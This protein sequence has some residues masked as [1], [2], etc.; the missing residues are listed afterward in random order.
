M[1]TLEPP[2]GLMGVGLCI[3]VPVIQIYCYRSGRQADCFAM[4][5]GLSPPLKTVKDYIL[6]CFESILQQQTNTLDTSC[7]CRIELMGIYNVSSILH[8]NRGYKV[9][10]FARNCVQLQHL[11]TIIFAAIHYQ[12]INWFF[13]AGL[14]NTSFVGNWSCLTFTCAHSRLELF[15]LKSCSWDDKRS[16]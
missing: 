5:R 10:V 1:F 3:R 16:T 15:C 2:N 6:A 14:R 11:E 7:A 4:S 9:A 8:G 13:L 12:K